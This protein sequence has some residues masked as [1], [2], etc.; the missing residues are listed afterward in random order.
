MLFLNR[1]HSARSEVIVRRGLAGIVYYEIVEMAG[2]VLELGR[3]CGILYFV[4]YSLLSARY[5]K[6]V[7]VRQGKHPHKELTQQLT[8]AAAS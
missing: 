5:N 6:A 3:G 1:C 8:K 7:I 2:M 4:C